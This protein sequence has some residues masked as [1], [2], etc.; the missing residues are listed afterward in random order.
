MFI[1]NTDLN[2]KRFCKTNFSVIQS[3]YS[4]KNLLIKAKIIQFCFHFPGRIT[5]GSSPG[6][7]IPV[8]GTGVL[9]LHCHIENSEGIVTI[10]P[11]SENLSIDGVRVN[12]PTRLSQGKYIY[13]I[14]LS[15]SCVFFFLYIYIVFNSYILFLSFEFDINN[16]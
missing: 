10:Y 3:L 9:P 8:Q 5:L 14:R 13:V 12:G 4:V 2:S 15:L 1:M 11:L 6:V 7:D 16:H